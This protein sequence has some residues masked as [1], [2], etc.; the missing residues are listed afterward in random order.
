MGVNSLG[1]VAL[2]VTDMPAWQKLLTSVFGVEFNLTA[3]GSSAIV[4][5]DEYQQRFTLY[6]TD[7]DGVA[8]IGWEVSTLSRLEAL[9]EQL[10]GQGITVEPGSKALCAERRVKA[11]YRFHEPHIGVETEIYYGPLIAQSPFTP[12]RGISGF[13]TAGGL[14]LGHIVYWVKDLQATLD[15]YM[16][17]MGFRISDYI[18]WDD[19]DAVFLHCNPR[20]HTLAVM[21]EAPG[22]PGGK[23]NHI[24]LEAKSIDDI[25][26]GYDIARDTQVPILIEVGKHTNDHM[27][28]FYLGTPSGFG[29]EYGYGA[30]LVDEDWEVKNY[31]QPMLWGHRPGR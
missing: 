27:Q 22:R 18:A 5:I 11:L 23:L 25:G 19:N 4:R 29:M 8:A 16:N 12:S 9:A 21:A 24:L 3:D 2:N 10:K 17:I 15:F 26:Y 7:A 14:G 20:H 13:N 30:R 6:R 1:Y 28:S 31:D